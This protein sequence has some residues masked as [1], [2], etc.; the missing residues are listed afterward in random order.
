MVKRLSASLENYLR[1]IF[2][3]IG[4]QEAVRAKDIAARMGVRGASVTGALRA[5]AKRGLINYEPYGVITLTPGGQRAGKELSRAR[6]ALS[7]FL[8][9]VLAVDRGRA[10]E[11]ACKME[12]AVSPEIMGRFREFF[13][14]MNACPYAGAAWIKGI[15][16]HC[17][18]HQ[19]ARGCE[20]C[21]NPRFEAK[22]RA[23][24]SKRKAAT[25]AAAKA[26]A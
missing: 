14:F 26:G 13:E 18:S 20:R 24:A 23:I 21:V 17:K 16:F 8:V 2:E 25:P 22:R 10:E 12:H 6:H 15:G 1:T 9:T 11:A 5:L 7:D 19:D 3:I 4:D